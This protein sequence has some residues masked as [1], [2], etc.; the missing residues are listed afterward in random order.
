MS[1]NTDYKNENIAKSAF[2]NNQAL[3]QNNENYKLNQRNKSQAHVLCRFCF[4]VFDKIHWPGKT[5]TDKH[6]GFK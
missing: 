4:D 6:S 3:E 5:K 1:N 2:S